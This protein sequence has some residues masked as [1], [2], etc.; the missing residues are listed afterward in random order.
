MIFYLSSNGYKNPF[1]E[2]IWF[3]KIGEVLA[4]VQIPPVLVG[5]KGLNDHST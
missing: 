3:F 4:Y 1:P 5:I 2:K